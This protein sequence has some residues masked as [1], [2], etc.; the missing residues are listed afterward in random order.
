[1]LPVSILEPQGNMLARTVLFVWAVYKLHLRVYRAVKA[2]NALVKSGVLRQGIHRLQ[3]SF[4][5]Q[6][7]PTASPNGST[8]CS[9]CCKN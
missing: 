7:S 1:M 9:F 4:P 5:L 3:S 2:Q 6:H 8:P